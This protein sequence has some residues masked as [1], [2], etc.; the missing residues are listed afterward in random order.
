MSCGFTAATRHQSKRKR[1]VKMVKNTDGFSAGTARGQ[2]CFKQP[3][4]MN[5]S[6][7]ANMMNK[8]DEGGSDDG[9]RRA[10]PWRAQS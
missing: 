9:N 10:T 3:A 5:N 4:Y 8:I 1:T 6:N 2:G 7:A